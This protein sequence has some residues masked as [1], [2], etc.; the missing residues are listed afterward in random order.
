M[1]P[2][3]L[4]DLPYAGMAEKKLRH[5]GLWQLTPHEKIENALGDLETALD[6]AQEAAENIEDEW[7]L[8]E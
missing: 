1:H 7:R 2:Q 8:I 4:M 5:A 6:K 3:E